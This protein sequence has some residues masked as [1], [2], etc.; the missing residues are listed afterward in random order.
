[1][2]GS[3]L[4][5]NFSNSA[6]D[7]LTD[8][9][10]KKLSTHIKKAEMYKDLDTFGSMDPYCKIKLGQV[11]KQT[12]CLKKAGKTPEWN[13]NF[14]FDGLYILDPTD[15]VIVELWDKDTM[16]DDFGGSCEIS[17]KEIHDHHIN[18]LEWHD[19]Y[20]KN[21]KAITGKIQ[22][23]FN[24]EMAQES[25]ISQIQ[26]S[27][28]QYQPNSM[29]DNNSQISQIQASHEKYQPN[30]MRDNNSQILT[31]QRSMGQSSRIHPLGNDT[32]AYMMNVDNSR[33]DSS[34]REIHKAPKTVKRDDDLSKITSFRGSSNQQPNFNGYKPKMVER[35]DDLS[36]ITSFRGSSNKQPNFNGY[37]PD[38]MHS[39]NM[40][41]ENIEYQVPQNMKSEKH[42]QNMGVLN[43]GGY[44]QSNSESNIGKMNPLQ[45]M[46][47]NENPDMNFMKK[48]FAGNKDSLPKS[49]KVISEHFV[50]NNNNINLGDDEGFI[51]GGG[52]NMLNNTNGLTTSHIIDKNGLIGGSGK[53]LLQNDGKNNFIGGSGKNIL[54]SN[55]GN[56][57]FIGGSNQQVQN[58]TGGVNQHSQNL[59]GGIN[60]QMGGVNQ[61]SQKLMGGLNQQ[62]QN[63][64]GGSG[65]NLPGDIA[66]NNLMGGINQKQQNLMGGLN[67]QQ[68]NLMGGSGKNLP[69]DIANNNLM[70]GINQKQ[71]NLMGGLNQQQQN[72]MGGSG[73]NLPGAIGNNNLLGG[74]GGGNNTNLLMAGG[75]LLPGETKNTVAKGYGNYKVN[76]E[77]EN[78]KNNLLGSNN[79]SS[80]NNF[81][82]NASDNLTPMMS[83]SNNNVLSNANQFF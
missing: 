35:D 73:K 28:E 37:K 41:P 50:Q 24:C 40:L 6:R 4:N 36:N 72:L 49:Q 5:N 13:E 76:Q 70:G 43:S 44:N 23:G 3:N 82:N 53:N 63:L 1:M 75:N 15:K 68:Q 10:F 48:G 31:K 26:A 67:Q 18:R 38:Q 51:S 34:F 33:L 2:E 77:K 29:R 45:Q 7:G 56:N 8:T 81:L 66:N 20:S 32:P 78:L 47:N 27:H 71:Q 25:Q 69:G 62:Q 59:T 83:N 54:G 11:V 14:T 79:N 52:G 60:Q 19:L 12:K 46:G 21:K 17:L 57:N 9:S 64:M 55:G 58:L 42:M 61:Q 65:K 16:G 80:S 22:L 30:S 74:G 39:N